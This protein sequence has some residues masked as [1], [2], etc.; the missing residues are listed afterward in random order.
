MPSASGCG[1]APPHPCIHAT[2]TPT[3]TSNARSPRP[4]RHP[5]IESRLPRRPNTKYKSS[6][7]APPAARARAPPPGPL[8]RCP[9]RNAHLPELAPR[10]TQREPEHEAVPRRDGG[11]LRRAGVQQ[12]RVGRTHAQGGRRHNNESANTHRGAGT[13]TSSSQAVS[14]GPSV[15]YAIINS[16]RCASKAHY[17]AR[18]ARWKRRETQRASTHLQRYGAVPHHLAAPRSALPPTSKTGAGRIFCQPARPQPARRPA[19]RRRV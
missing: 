14:A 8:E 15:P 19:P 16:K 2:S 3:S 4:S 10:A 9:T 1:S 6:L 18:C 13:D 7:S 11:R 17:F 5:E 12:R